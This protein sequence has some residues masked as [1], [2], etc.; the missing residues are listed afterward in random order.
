MQHGDIWRGVDLLAQKHGLTASGLARLA[1]LDA[2]AFNK[3]KRSSKD[4][5][6]RW[7]STESLSRALDAVELRFTDFA[8]LIDGDCGLSLP[9]IEFSEASVPQNFDP[10]G[11]PQG[12]QWEPVRF[13]G[14]D[15]SE[16]MYA[17]EIADAAY[18]PFY[19]RGSRLIISPSAPLRSGDRVV[20]K[21]TLGQVEA[22][23][24][25]RQTQ[26]RITFKSL[27]TQRVARFIATS[28]LAWIARILWVSQ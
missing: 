5:R 19:Q 8:N 12:E 15:S 4:G 2:T 11:R 27:N 7:P 20:T 3:S 22:Y 1:G 23:E 21:S 14:V 16:G 13:P 6:L 25:G 28:E 10:R 17:L 18:E 26:T 9:M 24:L